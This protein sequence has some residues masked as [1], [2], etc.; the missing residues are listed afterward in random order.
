MRTSR[1]IE[2]VKSKPK[3]RRCPVLV[4]ITSCT[5]SWSLA[6]KKKKKKIWKNVDQHSDWRETAPGL[7]PLHSVFGFSTM[8]QPERP[9]LGWSPPRLLLLV[10][11][12]LCAL[13]GECCVRCS[14]SRGAVLF[15]GGAEIL[16]ERSSSGSGRIGSRPPYALQFSLLNI[17]SCCFFFRQKTKKTKTK[18]TNPK[19]PPDF[20]LTDRASVRWRMVAADNGTQHIDRLL[21]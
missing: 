4:W 10:Y 3:G 19:N 15:V 14:D 5:N 8:W 18:K 20:R 12:S 9:G 1:H 16:P 2:V 17:H 11:T 7:E 6:K 13:G 21:L